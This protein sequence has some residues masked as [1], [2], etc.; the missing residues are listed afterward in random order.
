MIAASAIE[1]TS[2]SAEISEG[3]NRISVLA[4]ESSHAAEE[5]AL[6]CKNLSELATELDGIIRQFR[7]EKDDQPGSA[8]KGTR[9]SSAQV[10]VRHGA[11]RHLP[12]TNAV[13]FGP[14]PK[15]R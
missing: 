12:E 2:A 8:L 10:S 4:T 7:I 15:G 3:A 1:Q 11:S 5:S 9:R 14:Q 6:A 13:C